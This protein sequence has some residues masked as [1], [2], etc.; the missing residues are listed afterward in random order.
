[1]T[2]IILSRKKQQNT[3]ARVELLLNSIITD[4]KGDH[5]IKTIIL[6]TKHEQL[7]QLVVDSVVAVNQQPFFYLF[8]ENKLL[9]KYYTMLVKNR[10]YRVKIDIIKYAL[11]RCANPETGERSQII[12]ETYPSEPEIT[13]VPNN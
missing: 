13:I 2:Q 6:D 3:I 4:S 8:A 7:L 9:R 5:W 10:F 12:G 11:H 1:M